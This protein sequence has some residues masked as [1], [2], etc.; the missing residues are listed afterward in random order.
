M[1]VALFVLV[2]FVISITTIVYVYAESRQHEKTLPIDEP[3]FK[4]SI[5][6]GT[7]EGRDVEII[8]FKSKIGT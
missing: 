7:F 4:P 3:N 1:K 5:S 8:E 2:I 6:K